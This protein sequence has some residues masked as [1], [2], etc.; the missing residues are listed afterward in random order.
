MYIYIYVCVCVC[1]YI[2]TLVLFMRYFLSEHYQNAQND[3]N[4]AQPLRCAL[5][6]PQMNVMCAVSLTNH[7]RAVSNVLS[8]LRL[9][10]ATEQLINELHKSGV[11]LIA[12][13]LLVVKAE[14][15]YWNTIKMHK[16]MSSLVT[17]H[18]SLVKSVHIFLARNRVSKSCLIAELRFHR[19]VHRHIFSVFTASSVLVIKRFSPLSC[20]V[21]LMSL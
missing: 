18:I 16:T 13:T 6:S 20:S 9:I 1:V 2:Y 19:F 5:A 11:L 15:I 3:G 7:L 12:S 21:A 8:P 10:S 4:R 14:T 17:L